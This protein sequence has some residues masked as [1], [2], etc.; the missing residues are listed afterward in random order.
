MRQSAFCHLTFVHGLANC[1]Y[2][3]PPHMVP[4]ISSEGLVFDL[5][6]GFMTR[7]AFDIFP[8]RS[9]LKQIL[10]GP[11]SRLYRAAEG[12]RRVVFVRHGETDFN[13]AGKIQ[14]ALGRDSDRKIKIQRANSK[15][16]S[17]IIHLK[18]IISF[19]MREKRK[20]MLTYRFVLLCCL[21]W[22]FSLKQCIFL[23]WREPMRNEARSSRS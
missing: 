10:T 21:H 20:E 18:I 7:V 15:S 3:C 23:D 19:N 11:L 8:L 5:N 2:A 9:F 16:K 12:R 13:L 1:V 4:F 17:S 22:H 14:G 6:R